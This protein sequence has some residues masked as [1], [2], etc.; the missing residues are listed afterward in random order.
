MAQTSPARIVTR[1]RG[2]PV[3]LSPMSQTISS[4][5]C[6]NHSTRSLPWNTGRMN[7]SV[8]GQNRLAPHTEVTEGFQVTSE[9]DRYLNRLKACSWPSK[10]GSTWT[11]GSS[12]VTSANA[13]LTGRSSRRGESPGR[14]GMRRVAI[15]ERSMASA[16]SPCLRPKAVPVSSGAAKGSKPSLVQSCSM[17]LNVAM[18]SGVSKVSV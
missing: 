16:L 5:S 17:A 15:R 8:V 6:R 2:A 7:S 11:S 4:D 13:R 12:W 14:P 1:A 18:M 3:S 9:R 10:P